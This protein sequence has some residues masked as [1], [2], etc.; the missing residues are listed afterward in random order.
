MF[1][2]TTLHFLLSEI[3]DSKSGR[4]WRKGYFNSPKQ[5]IESTEL[6]SLELILEFS[7]QSKFFQKSIWEKTDL[8][9]HSFV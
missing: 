9:L 5:D 6:D 4:S 3:L 2:I 1:K 8:S 7:S